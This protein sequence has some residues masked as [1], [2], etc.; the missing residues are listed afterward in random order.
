MSTDKKRVSKLLYYFSTFDGGVYYSGKNARFVINMRSDNLDYI[1]WIED[2]INEYTSV[3]IRDVIQRGNRMPLV[4]LTSKA[5]PIFTK[6]RERIYID[7]KKVI[8]PHTLALMDA[9][10]LAIIFMADGGTSVDK[11]HNTYPEI[12]LHTKGFSYFENL[13]LSKAIYE[14]TSIRT[15]VNRHGKYFFLRVKSA[16]IQLFVDTVKPYLC[17]SFYYK[18]ERL[19]PTGVVI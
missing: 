12:R 2:T 15:T 1:G 3:I 17:E 18:L 7:N 14:K 13:A 5:H 19:A 6:I 16:D 10:A 8:D 4:S 11:R 9:E